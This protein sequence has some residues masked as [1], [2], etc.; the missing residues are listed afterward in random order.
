MK[1]TARQLRQPQTE[2]RLLL[3]STATAGAA[4]RHHFRLGF[5]NCGTLHKLHMLN[6]L[7]T[8]YKL[9]MLHKLHMQH[10]LHRLH[11]LH[12]QVMSVSTHWPEL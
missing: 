1:R 2:A 7:R 6:K 10:K 5:H 8:L 9:H 3:Q 4:D 11:M 12:S